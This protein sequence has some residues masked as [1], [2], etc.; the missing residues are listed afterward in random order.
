MRS[1]RNM[2]DDYLELLSWG[3]RSRV[4]S[5]MGVRIEV[6]IIIVVITTGGYEC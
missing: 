1:L 2:P 4:S 6:D 5:L 3:W